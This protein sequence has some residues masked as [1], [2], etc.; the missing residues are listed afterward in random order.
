MGF[1]PSSSPWKVEVERPVTDSWIQFSKGFSYDFE[2]YHNLERLKRER[3]IPPFLFKLKTGLLLKANWEEFASWMEVS[4]EVFQDNW[5]FSTSCHRA[6]PVTIS[7][8]AFRRLLG[9]TCNGFF[10]CSRVR[11][12]KRWKKSL[13]L[14]SEFKYREICVYI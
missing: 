1:D 9:E 10:R 7:I 14:F 12:R 6:G 4:K 8:A 13:F 2:I 11:K 3:Y 5:N